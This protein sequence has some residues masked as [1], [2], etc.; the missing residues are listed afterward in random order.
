MAA[1]RVRAAAAQADLLVGLNNLQSLDLNFTQ[2]CGIC[3]S[4]SGGRALLDSVVNLTVLMRGSGIV[5]GGVP[6]MPRLRRLC[7]Y[8]DYDLRMPGG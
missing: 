7:F 6:H 2:L 3:L 4:P 1:G 5:P 8:D